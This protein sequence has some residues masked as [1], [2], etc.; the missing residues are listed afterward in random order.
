MVH[1]DKY[2]VTFGGGEMSNWGRY[3]TLLPPIDGADA[4]TG[5]VYFPEPP[6][7]TGSHVGQHGHVPVHAQSSTSP[8]GRRSVI[9]TS[10]IPYFAGRGGVTPPGWRNNGI[11]PVLYMHERSLIRNE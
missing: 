7:K 4:A 10:D 3:L 6:G 2:A 9:A 8:G 11:P 5:S 1:K